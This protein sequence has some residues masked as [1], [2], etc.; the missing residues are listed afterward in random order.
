MFKSNSFSRIYPVPKRSPAPEQSPAPHRR[1]GAGQSSVLDQSRTETK[2]LVRGFWCGAI[3]LTVGVITMVLLIGSIILAWTEPSQ[4]PPGTNVLPPLQ[5][6]SSA[7]NLAGPTWSER[8]VLNINYLT[9]NDDIFL[10][11]NASE[12]ASV[13]IAGNQI[14]FYTSST[15]RLTIDSSG[16]LGIGTT[17][18]QTH[19]QISSATT[20]GTQLSLRN[21]GTGGRWWNLYSTGSGNSEGAGKFLLRDNTAGSVRMTVDSSGNVGIGTT[22]PAYPLSVNGIVNAT[23]FYKNGLVFSPSQ[24]TTISTGIYYNSGNVG[25]GT[26]NPGNLLTIH[27]LTSSSTQKSSLF[28]VDQMSLSQLEGGAYF[29][30]VGIKEN[31]WGLSNYGNTWTAKRL[32]GDGYGIYCIAMSSDGKIQTTGIYG[33]QIYVSYDY[34]NTWTAKGSTGKWFSVAMSSDGKIQTAGN[35]YGSQ[36]IYVSYDYGNTWTAKGPAGGYWYSVAM[37]SDGKIQTAG[38]LGSRIYVSYD[39]GNTWTAKGPT[40]DWR[41]LAMSSDGK[42]QTVGNA[43]RQIYV[44]YDYGN[45]WTA[46][47]PT[48]YWYSIAMSSDGKIQTAGID[49]GQ[50]RQIYVS[51]DYGDSWTA[52]GPSGNWYGVAI[53]SDGKIQTAAPYGGQI[54][55]SIDYGNTWTAKGSGASW[56]SVAMSSDGKIQ[57]A[58]IDAGQ[59]AVFY[60]DS[61]IQGNV[62]IG[63]TGPATKLQVIGDIRVG[64]SGTNGCVQRYDGTALTGT[65]SSDIRL[66]E[67]IK[68]LN[69]SLNKLLG[70]KPVTYTPKGQNTTAYGLIA[71][72]V[73]QVIPEFVQVDENGYKTVDYGIGLQMLM[74]NA[75]NEQQEK[76]EEQQQKIEQLKARTEAL[77]AKL[78]VGQ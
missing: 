26:T 35:Y 43:S 57:T 12:T 75:I 68:P 2:F 76:I 34:G 33:G 21:T 50:G 58:S 52:K 77:E 53:S 38:N 61:Y 62:G 70:L 36:Q 31:Q 5:A 65:C 10:K 39:Y 9:G 47:G 64:T 7:L 14:R 60:A 19:L 46:K 16:N 29:G 51:Y 4:N 56:T 30:R 55:V 24:W 11:G 27:S 6:T 54:Y 41:G 72:D 3:A 69:N 48:G 13:Y 37:S 73:E 15:E 18:P 71:Q 22:T 49:A 17:T 23:D 25:I 78:N 63:T 20:G 45:S 8:N 67:N 44:S 66:K 40:G 42:I 28:S 1:S 74:I 59:V 32:A